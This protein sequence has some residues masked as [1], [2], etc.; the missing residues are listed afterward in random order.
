MNSEFVTWIR[1]IAIRERHSGGDEPTAKSLGASDSGVSFNKYDIFSR[2]N[3]TTPEKNKIRH[4]HV[5][6]E[7][8]YMKKKISIVRYIVQE[9]EY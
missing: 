1:S 2:W 9:H 4:T 7:L 5:D 8:F 3:V 6:F